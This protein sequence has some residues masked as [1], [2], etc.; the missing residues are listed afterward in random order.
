MVYTMECELTGA[1]GAGGLGSSSGLSRSLSEAVGR[2]QKL[3][4][5]EPLLLL[6]G[7]NNSRTRALGRD[8]NALLTSSV[9]AKSLNFA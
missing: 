5:R 7:Q 1:V 6:K 4:N 2:P 9:M 3:Q 8:F